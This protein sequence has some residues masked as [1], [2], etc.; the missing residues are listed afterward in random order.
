MIEDMVAS[1]RLRDGDQ[2]PTEEDLRAQYGV[3]RGTHRAD[4]AQIIRALQMQFDL[5]D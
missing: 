1:S 4:I 3:S 5:E 2:L